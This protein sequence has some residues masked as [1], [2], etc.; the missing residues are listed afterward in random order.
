MS[1]AN[2]PS[3]SNQTSEEGGGG[4]GGDGGGGSKLGTEDAEEITEDEIELRFQQMIPLVAQQIARMEVT[5]PEVVRVTPVFR[6]FE[7]GAVAFRTEC[8]GDFY[9][10]SERSEKISTFWSHSWHGGHWKKI[11]TLITIY[12]G[13]AAS[14]LG[15]LSALV[16]MLLFCLDLLP[17]LDRGRTGEYPIGYSCWSLWA[18]FLVTSL[19]MILWRPQSR[20]FLDR[21]CISQTDVAL[22][23]QAIFSLAGLLKKSDSMLILWDPSWTER[24]WCLFELAAFLQSKKDLKKELIIR[25]TFLGPVHIAVF[26]TCVAGMIP[27]TMAPMDVNSGPTSLVVPSIFVCASGF[28]AFYVAMSTLRRYFRDL[29]IMKQQ[30]LSISFDTARSSCCDT[31]HVAESGAPVFCDRRIVKECVNVWFGS[32]E[33]FE[34]ILRSEILAILTH[35]LTERIFSTK[36]SLAMFM[37]L[38]WGLMDISASEWQLPAKEFWQRSALAFLLHG[39]SIWLVFMPMLKDVLILVGKLTRRRPKSQ[40]LEVMKNFLSSCTLI[41]PCAIVMATYAFSFSLTTLL[42]IERAAVFLG[43]ILCYSMVTWCLTIAIKAAL[44]GT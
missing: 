41:V 11:I 34:N 6:T 18:G 15:M 39:L 24:L 33:A 25:P 23:T 8:T 16:M 12:N 28:A 10:K 1:G 31:N 35:D 14:V 42:P 21:I 2:H 7:K 13:P 30:L 36:S 20:V 17:S 43:C 4:G 38:M 22:K 37:P 27:L 9:F 26:L 44:K 19:A 5:S 29:D 3:L 40:C 32:E